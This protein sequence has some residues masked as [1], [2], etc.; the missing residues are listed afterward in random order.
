MFVYFIFNN[1]VTNSIVPNVCH[2]GAIISKG[3]SH[4]VHDFLGLGW[5]VGWGGARWGMG[6]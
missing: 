1:N 6:T 3:Y 5:G 4:V 2:N